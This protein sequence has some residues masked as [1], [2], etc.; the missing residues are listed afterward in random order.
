MIDNKKINEIKNAHLYY[1]NNFRHYL[2]KDNLRDLLIS[3]SSFDNNIKLWNINKLECLL[4]IKNIYKNGEIFSSC[5]LNNNNKLFIVSSNDYYPDV[6][7]PIKVFNLEGILIK[8]IKN[9]KERT[10]FIDTFYD[11]KAYKNYIFTGNKNFI[12]SYD[13]DRNRLFHIYNDNSLEFHCSIIIYQDNNEAVTKLIESS[14]DGN[15]RIWNF[16]TGD[17]IKKIEVI[18]NRKFRL[19]GICLWDKDNLFVGCNDKTIK[20]VNLNNKSIIKN[21]EGHIEFPITIKKIIHPLY[22]KCLISEGDENDTI[23]LWIIQK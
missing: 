22:G 11:N 6:P 12:K 17:L 5:F 21:L 3:I 2:D 14:N 16:H 18:K 7:G 4:D 1:I 9:S 15:I 8:I 23:K 13:Y 20:L 19:Y 10:F